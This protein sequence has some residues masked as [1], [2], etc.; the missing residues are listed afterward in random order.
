MAAKLGQVAYIH[1]SELF[2][3]PRWREGLVIGTKKNW[4]QL[5][6][7]GRSRSE[8]PEGT[9][10]FTLN[11]R[12][13]FLLECPIHH[14][15]AAC[16]GNPME[17]EESTSDLMREGKNALTSDTELQFAT[18]SDPEPRKGKTAPEPAEDSS[19]SDS[20]DE[21]QLTN[22][23]AKLQRSRQDSGTKREKPVIEDRKGSAKRF[24]YLEK[25]KEHRDRRDSVKDHTSQILKN[26]DLDADP[27]KA[28]MA[29]QLVQQLESSQRRSRR[30]R[31]PSPGSD[32][33]QSQTSSA[34]SRSSGRR[35][36]GHARA[37]ENYHAGKK[38]MFRR[39]LHYVKKYVKEVESSLGAAD[40]PFRLSEAGKRI[41]WGKQKSLQRVHYMFSEVLE[42]MLKGKM[43]KACLQVVLCL[44]SIHQCAI[45]QDWGVA[46]MVSHLDDPF[47]KPKWG[48]DVAELSNVAAYLKSMAELEKTTE[49]LRSTASSSHDQQQT[50]PPDPKKKAKKK[51]KGKGSEKDEEAV[52][53]A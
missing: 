32:S 41:N 7:R 28:L 20:S 3:E 44:R 50:A 33:D 5:V 30:H 42:L 37:V 24:A 48:G 21:G 53:K 1:L 34:T 29:L 40:R 36:S 13:F 31:H 26:V 51:G 2:A 18:A 49:K 23:L 9:T 43:D 4:V 8:L 47:T 15:R 52:D 27:I 14:L 35:R 38:R 22:V 10:Q 12:T 16:P 45:D 6:V 46:W 17:L 25:T 19:S 39:P 11:S